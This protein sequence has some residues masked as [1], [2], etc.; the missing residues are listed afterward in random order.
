MLEC[1]PLMYKVIMRLATI[2]SVA[3]TEALAALKQCASTGIAE[4]F[5]QGVRKVL[6]RFGV[7]DPARVPTDQLGA[8][9][10]Q[11]VLAQLGGKLGGQVSNTDLQ[12]VKDMMGST[13]TDTQALKR[14]LAIGAAASISRLSEYNGEVDD[15]AAL[16]NFGYV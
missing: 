5:L 4:P 14:L 6:A 9:L 12:F 15:V 2:D 1:A 11:R 10:A 8:V 13:S 16:P 3:T 7:D